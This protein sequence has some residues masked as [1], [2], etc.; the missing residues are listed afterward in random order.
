[1]ISAVCRLSLCLCVHVVAQIYVSVCGCI[2][3]QVRAHC[4]NRLV[5]TFAAN[6]LWSRLCSI[7]QHFQGP[8]AQP[9]ACLTPVLPLSSSP[10][11][12]QA[13]GSN[14]SDCCSQRRTWPCKNDGNH[15]ILAFSH[16]RP[17]VWQVEKVMPEK[18]VCVC[19]LTQCG[20]QMT[21]AHTLDYLHFFFSTFLL[22]D[23]NHR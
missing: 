18:T 9:P 8:S 15:F 1:M 4:I 23:A 6:S 21:H 2:H 14:A 3:A 10:L 7:N 16:T 5:L 20:V 12:S 22:F 11:S 19:R 17:S 13:R